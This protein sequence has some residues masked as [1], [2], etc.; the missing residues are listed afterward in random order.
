[1]SICAK[2]VFSQNCRDVKNEGFRK[3]SSIFC[4]CLFDVAARETEKR[5]NKIE[6]GPKQPI[7]IVL[8]RWSPE[9]E[10][11]KKIDF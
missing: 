7:K 3:E 9:N 10:K 6:K 8:L 11:M 2:I 4:F 5:K 1:M